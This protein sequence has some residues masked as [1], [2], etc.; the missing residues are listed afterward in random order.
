MKVVLRSDVEGLG[1]KGDICDVA[2]GYAR[3]Y[4]VPRGLALKSSPGTEQQAAAMRR[5]AAMAHAAGR[6]DAEAI[7]VRLAPT[8]IAVTAKATDAGHL[9]GS[10]GAKD[11][12]DAVEQQLGAVVEPASVHLEASIRETGAHSVM[13]RLHADVQVPVTVEVAAE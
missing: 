2:A 5:A 9:Y 3:N 4:L 6:A 11:I 12:A 1:R 7:A 13:F 10:V 8:V